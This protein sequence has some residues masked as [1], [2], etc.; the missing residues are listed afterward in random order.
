M[1]ENPE[2]E[3]LRADTRE[4]LIKAPCEVVYGAFSNPD[5]LTRWWGPDGFTNSFYE[6]DLRK[7]GY[8]R[9]TMH[10]PDARDY[11]NESRFLEVVPGKKVVIEHFSGHHFILTMT[12]TASGKDTIVGWCQLFDTIEHYQRIA[13]FVSNANEQNLDRLQTVVRESGDSVL[14]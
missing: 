5:D 13:D 9:F 6:F 8:W 12:F 7:G 1:A 2:P 10:G 4:R 3:S 14:C 11:P